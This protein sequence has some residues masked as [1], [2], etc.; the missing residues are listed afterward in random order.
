MTRFVLIKARVPDW[1]EAA[2]CAVI[3]VTENLILKLDKRIAQTKALFEDDFYGTRWWDYSPY[4]VMSGG[5]ET[6]DLEMDE[7]EFENRLDACES[8]VL[9]EGY[10]V[11]DE[12]ASIDPLILTIGVTHDYRINPKGNS[13]GF[14]WSGYDKHIGDSAPVTTYEMTEFELDE[15]AKLI[16]CTETLKKVRSCRGVEDA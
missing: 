15:W 1:Y 9:P 14:K 7:D 3:E 4:F 6:F 16:G 5:P 11:P 10:E 12:C 13:A 8:I 2:D